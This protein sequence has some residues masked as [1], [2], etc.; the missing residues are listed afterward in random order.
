M[1]ALTQQCE[2]ISMNRPI[3]SYLLPAVCLSLFL[4]GC[5][6]YTP[7]SPADESAATIQIVSERFMH[8]VYILEID[9]ARTSALPPIGLVSGPSEIKVS[10]GRH[11]FLVEGASG[12]TAWRTKLWLDVEV[13]RTYYLRSENKGYSFRAWFQES[14]KVDPVG[15]ALPID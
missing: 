9:G 3:L 12:S 10:P 1:N 4:G 6:T 7:P 2:K 11:T 15:G 8:H 13:K 14:G 5:T